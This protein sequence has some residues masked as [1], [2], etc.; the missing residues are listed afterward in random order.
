MEVN[1]QTHRHLQ[2]A[3]TSHPQPRYAG[4]QRLPLPTRVLPPSEHADYHQWPRRGCSDTWS[5]GTAGLLPAQQQTFHSTN[6]LVTSKSS[7]FLTIC[8]IMTHAKHHTGAR[9]SP[10]EVLC[11]FAKKLQPPEMTHTCW[12]RCAQLLHTAFRFHHVSVRHAAPFNY[13]NTAHYCE[14]LSALWNDSKP[15]TTASLQYPAWAT[16]DSWGS[17]TTPTAVKRRCFS[18]AQIELPEKSPRSFRKPE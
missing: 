14:M 11:S 13:S 4:N 1:L 12:A 10:W 3:A 5:D 2:R 8:G 9:C 17:L 18:I 16:L 7:A 15:P 6:T